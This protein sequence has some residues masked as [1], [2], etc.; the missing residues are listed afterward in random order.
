[1]GEDLEQYFYILGDNVYAQ[2]IMKKNLYQ[3]Q[4]EILNLD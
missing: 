2:I 3:C 4:K 1:M